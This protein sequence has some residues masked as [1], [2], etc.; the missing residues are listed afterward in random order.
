MSDDVRALDAQL[1][2]VFE[3]RRRELV[4]VCPQLRRI[5]SAGVSNGFVIH[6]GNIHHV[7]NQVTF[8]FQVPLQHILKHEGAKVTYV[9]VV[10]NCRPAGVHSDLL[11]V[12]RMK[13]F[14]LPGKSI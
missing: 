4:R 6:V 10:V 3:E 13:L 7:G 1:A 8:E 5:G 11:F 12:Q 2:A 14:Q 9:G